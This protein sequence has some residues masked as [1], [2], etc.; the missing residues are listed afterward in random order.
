[1]CVVCKEWELGKLT[2]KEALKNLGE[3]INTSKDKEKEHYF[4]ASSKIL[5]KEVKSGET[6]EELDQIWYDETRGD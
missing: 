5:D 2:S 6:D 1:M 4:E 3:M